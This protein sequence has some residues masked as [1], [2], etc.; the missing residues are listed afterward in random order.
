MSPLQH[1]HSPNGHGLLGR[2][3]SC[4]KLQRCEGG[5]LEEL[6]DSAVLRV[7]DGSASRRVCAWNVEDRWRQPQLP[8]QRGSPPPLPPSSHLATTCSSGSRAGAAARGSCSRRGGGGGG[9]GSDRGGRRRRC[10][11][12]Q[13]VAQQAGSTRWVV[14]EPNVGAWLGG[15]RVLSHAAAA[16]RVPVCQPP[17]RP[18]LSPCSIGCHRR[19]LC[20]AR[21]GVRTR[22]LAA[23]DKAAAKQ[24]GLGDEQGG[25]WP[26]R[27]VLQAGCWAAPP[28]KPGTCRHSPSHLLSASRCCLSPSSPHFP[29]AA[30]QSSLTNVPLPLQVSLRRPPNLAPAGTPPVT[31]LVPPA[32]VCPPPALT[33]P[34]Q[35][36]SHPSQTCPFPFRSPSRCSY[37]PCCSQ[38]WPLRWQLHPTQPSWQPS[39]SSQWPRSVGAACVAKPAGL[40]QPP[41]CDGS[42]RRG[43]DGLNISLAWSRCTHARCPPASFVC[44][45]WRGLR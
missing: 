33:S 8:S 15:C 21:H 5:L 20:Q 31:F 16:C 19:R 12:P 4:E 34:I 38:K 23:Q 10:C 35:L 41:L 1:H 43:S 9:G 18:V 30:S 24:H 28:A 3:T 37:P 14:G 39:A 29:H 13:P 22:R 7:C 27:R 26:A 44:R 42:R 17:E 36:L 6:D 25:C 2:T 32:A 11:C 40:V 45:S